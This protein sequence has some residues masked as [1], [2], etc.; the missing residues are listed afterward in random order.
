VLWFRQTDDALLRVSSFPG[1]VGQAAF[2]LLP[3]LVLYLAI[4]W[5][6]RAASV[7]GG[8]MTGLM[9][10]QWWVSATDWHSTASLGPGVTGFFAIPTIVVAGALLPGAVR[11]RMRSKP[12][13]RP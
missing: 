13:R 8:A 1:A 4:V 10:W 7:I 6:S 11:K 3:S 5:T 9:A 12:A 2:W